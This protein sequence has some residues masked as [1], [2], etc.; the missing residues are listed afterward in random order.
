METQPAAAVPR[1][2][3]TRRDVLQ[4]AALGAAALATG[5]PGLASARAAGAGLSFTGPI[6]TT[7]MSKPW[8]AVMD[9]GPREAA[10]RQYDYVEEEFFLAGTANVYGPKPGAGA[11]AGISPMVYAEVLAPLSTLVRRDVPFMTR[12]TVVRPRNMAEFSGKVHLVP[13]HNLDATSYVE[14]N[15]MREGSVWMGLEVCGGTRFGVEEQLSGGVVNLRKV[16]PRR[17]GKLAIPAGLPGDWP[18]LQPGRLGEAFKQINFMK[19]TDP[20]NIFRQEI[21][22]GYAQAPDIITKM[23]QALRAG[24][25]GNPLAGHKVRYIYTAGRSGQSTILQPYVDYHHEPA[26]QRL[27][28]VPFDGYQIRVGS[29]PTARP[30]GSVLMIVQSEAEAQSVPPEMLHRLADSDDPMF[31]YYEIPGVGHGLT[32]RPNVSG[33][34]GKIIPKGVQGLSNIEGESQYQPF[35]K[36]ALPLQWAMWRNLYDWVEKGIPMPRAPRIDRDPSVPG[37][38]ARDR[39]GNATGG[40]RTPWMN[41]PDARYVGIIHENNPLEGGMMPFGKARIAELYGSEEAYRRKLDLALQAMVRDRWLLEQD[42]PLMR[43]RG[44]SPALAIG[45]ANYTGSASAGSAPAH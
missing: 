21:S 42:I 18:E 43:V 37:A 17:Y 13:L 26:R 2:Q 16:D 24:A 41:Y 44:V 25:P 40:L 10:T 36:V 4:G 34:I 38:L 19:M 1:R 11:S 5:W 27:G 9:G 3:P 45:Y 32:G 20:S 15:L 22:R 39:F 28:Q 33:N 30:T 6:P 12:V 8:G 7:A 23:A 29:M 31:R 35:D 14:I